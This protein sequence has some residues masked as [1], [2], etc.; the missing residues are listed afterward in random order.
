MSL[1]SDTDELVSYI[2]EPKARQLAD[3]ART[4]FFGVP[5]Q[6]YDGLAEA[7]KGFN[8]KYASAKYALEALQQLMKR[9]PEQ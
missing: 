4:G 3:L 9:F 6:A 1:G 2:G 8:G 5:Q 7:V